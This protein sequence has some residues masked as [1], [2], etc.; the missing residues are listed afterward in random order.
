VS[1]ATGK[2]LLGELP[3]TKSYRMK[4]WLTSIFLLVGSALLFQ[5]LPYFLMVLAQ[6]SSS[7]GDAWMVPVFMALLGGLLWLGAITVVG[8]SLR[9][10]V[11]VGTD[12]NERGDRFSFTQ[13]LRKIGGK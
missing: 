12:G 6:G 7:D 2:V 9:Y 5:A 4:K 1:G 10:E 8:E 13:T 11:E 3:V